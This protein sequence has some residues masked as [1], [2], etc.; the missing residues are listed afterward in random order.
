MLIEGQII[1]ST[2]TDSQGEQYSKE[3]LEALVVQTTGL[4]VPLHS[5]HDL[6]RR[7]QGSLENLRLERH[8]ENSEIWVIRADVWLPDGSDFN[9]V[10]AAVG[11][12]SWSCTIDVKRNCGQTPEFAIYLPYPYYRDESLEADLLATEVPLRTGRWVKKAADPSEIALVVGLFILTPIW[13]D[14]WK[15]WVLPRLQSLIP[16]LRSLWSKGISTHYIQRVTTATGLS[17]YDVMFV[18]GKDPEVSLSVWCITLGLGAAYKEEGRLRQ[19][20][21]SPKRIVMLFDGAKGHYR[22]DRIETT[23][24]EVTYIA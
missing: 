13:E 1:A 10:N 5:H 3:F 7:P 6:A 22:V 8:S 19:K 21:K 23:D 11:G 4:K 18:P 2:S 16:K 14:A 24:G 15:S 12:F 9:D 17:E 20:G